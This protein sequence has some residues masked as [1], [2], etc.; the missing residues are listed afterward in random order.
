MSNA[1]GND[2]LVVVIGPTK[3]GKTALLSSLQTAALGRPSDMK[4]AVRVF[5]TSDDMR[6]LFFKGAQVIDEGRPPLGATGTVAVYEFDLEVD[7]RNMFQRLLRLPPVRAKFSFVDGPGGAL[8]GNAW[9]D[10]PNADVNAIRAYR[11]RLVAAARNAGSLMICVDPTA[12]DGSALFFRFLPDFFAR[13][14]T[15]ELSYNRIAIVLTK[16]DEYFYQQGRGALSAA[17]DTSALEVGRRLIGTQ[18]INAITQ[19]CPQATITFSWLSAFGFVTATGE[20]N[21]NPTTGGLLVHGA[22]TTGEM[23]A[24]HW[25]PF[26]ILDPLMFLAMGDA[27]GLEV[28]PK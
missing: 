23:V 19:Y 11:D 24:K 25:Q 15:S 20:A 3:V 22:N 16:A 1:Q 2:R 8:F 26:R 10:D 27:T 4:P 5:P 7:N 21:F 17:L 9:E 13:V 28:L 6:E 18:G 12:V 14:G